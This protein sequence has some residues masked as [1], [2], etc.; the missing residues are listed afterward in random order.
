MSCVMAFTPNIAD[1]KETHQQLVD[2]SLDDQTV[3]WLKEHQRCDRM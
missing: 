1:G 3:V 2:T